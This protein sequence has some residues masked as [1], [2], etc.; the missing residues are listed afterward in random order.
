MYMDNMPSAAQNIPLFD[1]LDN[2][3][4]LR[5]NLSICPNCG[6]VQLNNE[7]VSYYKEV[8]RSGGISSTMY[9]LRKRQYSHFIE[10]CNLDGKDIIEVGCGSGEFLRIFKEFNVNAYGTEEKLELVNNAL[11]DNLRVVRN[12]PDSENKILYEENGKKMFD[13]FTSFNFLEHQPEPIKYLRCIYNNLK[14]EA[15]GLITVPALSYI[16]DKK[17]YYE[18]II[19]HLAYYSLESLE[20]L[21]NSTGFEVIFSEIINRDTISVIVKKKNDIL[22]LSSVSEKYIEDVKKGFED[23]KSQMQFIEKDFSGLIDYYKSL[24]KKVAI[25][26]AG[27][28]GF[29]IC[30]SLNLGGKVEYIIDSSVFKQNR[31]SPASHIPIISFEDAKKNPVDAIIIIAP[32][33]SNEIK[34]IIIASDIE[35][36]IYTLMREKIDRLR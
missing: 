3:K 11:E 35:A 28:Q 4:S 7:P 14:D 30:S 15:Y 33:Y 17:S 25:W 22:S 2:D 19:D 34:N 31:Y 20:Y 5:L 26:G 36:D 18:I 1:E 27:H 9:N 8:I 23:V 32:G 29:C 12:F 24:N 10:L 6:L 16:L 13:A 21:L